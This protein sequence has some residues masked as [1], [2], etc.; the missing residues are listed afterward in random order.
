MH[1]QL[2]C[3]TFTAIISVKTVKDWHAIMGHNGRM[4]GF[5]SSMQHGLTLKTPSMR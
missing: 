3:L 5:K 1:S 4:P 2:L